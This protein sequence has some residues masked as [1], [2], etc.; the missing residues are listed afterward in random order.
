MP[1]ANSSSESR[2][3]KNIRN[4]KN[5]DTD[6]NDKIDKNNHG[7]RGRGHR[8]RG[9]RSAA[10]PMNAAFDE[11]V[12]RS[13]TIGLRLQKEMLEL[14]SDIGQ[15]WMTRATAEAELALRLPNELGAARSVP[16]AVSAY[17]QWF[18]EWMSAFD[19]NSRRFVSDNRRIVDTGVRCLAEMAPAGMS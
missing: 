18:S 9:E 6:K 16:D 15:D 11:M 14:I 1:Q 12:A 8:S 13:A 3:S 17:Q 4:S 19:H 2:R 10:T 5:T 7:E